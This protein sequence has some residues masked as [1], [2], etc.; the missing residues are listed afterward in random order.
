MDVFFFFFLLFLLPF[1]FSQQEESF[2][3]TQTAFDPPNSELCYFPFPKRRRKKKITSTSMIPV[4]ECKTKNTF[5]ESIDPSFLFYLFSI[6]YSEVAFLC[7]W[8][9][10]QYLM[11]KQ[12]SSCKSFENTHI[13]QNRL[14][15][16]LI[17]NH[18]TENVQTVAAALPSLISSLLF[19]VAITSLA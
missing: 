3:S 14:K 1:F 8:T 9:K 11:Y 4:K 6:Q 15:N 13:P 12:W 5:G 19:S 10:H 7:S 16:Y 17:Y 18:N 2:S